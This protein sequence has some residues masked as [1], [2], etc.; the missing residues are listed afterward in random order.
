MFFLF[1]TSC[2]N[3]QSCQPRL[4]PLAAQTKRSWKSP[5]CKSHGPGAPGIC[6]EHWALKWNSGHGMLFQDS[7]QGPE[8]SGTPLSLLN[9]EAEL[10]P[11]YFLTGQEVKKMKEILGSSGVSPG[12]DNLMSETMSSARTSLSPRPKVLRNRATHAVNTQWCLTHR[13]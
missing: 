4:S 5:A 12:Q 1:G 13:N 7:H 2:L 8:A 3:S 6:S 11:H 9:R 10:R